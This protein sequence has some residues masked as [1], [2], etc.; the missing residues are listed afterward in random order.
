MHASKVPRLIVPFQLIYSLQHIVWDMSFVLCFEMKSKDVKKS[1]VQPGPEEGEFSLH[2]KGQHEACSICRRIVH[3]RRALTEPQACICCR[4]SFNT[5]KA[6]RVRGKSEGSGC[7]APLSSG[8]LLHLSV[9]SKDFR[10][11]SPLVTELTTWTM[12]H[13]SLKDI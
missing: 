9:M 5:R 6:G 1:F 4:H 13:E 7:M 10:L 8:T 12:K 11:K 2:N 3:N